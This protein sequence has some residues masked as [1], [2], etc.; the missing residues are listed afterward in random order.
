MEV[1]GMQTGSETI[2]RWIEQISL[3]WESARAWALR[4][5]TRERL[6]YLAL[7]ISTLSVTGLIVLSLHRALERSTLVSALPYLGRRQGLAQFHEFLEMRDL[8]RFCREL[9]R[10][11]GGSGTSRLL[12]ETQ[13]LPHVRWDRLSPV[14]GSWR[15]V[16]PPTRMARDSC[17]A[18]YRD[19]PTSHRR[20]QVMP[21]QSSVAATG[22][23]EQYM[24]L[25]LDSRPFD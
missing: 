14:A 10:N 11:A 22:C 21:A 8:F 4:T 20:W 7:G 3:D 16:E 18:S 23:P 24:R 2:G 6:T 19:L 13:N 5:L 15:S 25:A 17:R 1:M 9:K 12:P